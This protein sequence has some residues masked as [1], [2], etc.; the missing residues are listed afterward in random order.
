MWRPNVTGIH[1]KPTVKVIQT[2]SSNTRIS[3]IP[4]K[5]MMQSK[6]TNL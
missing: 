5:T 6:L 3:T 2:S 4:T 1:S